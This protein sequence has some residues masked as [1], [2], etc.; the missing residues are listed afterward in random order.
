MTALEVGQSLDRYTIEALVGEGGMGQVYRAFDTRLR[1]HVALKVLR[2][3]EADP[4]AAVAEVLREA[5]AAAAIAHPNVTA[6]LDAGELEGRAFIAMEYVPGT[7]LRRLIGAA[8]VTLAARLRWLVDIAAALAAA[9]QVGVIHRDIKP[10]NV[11]VREDGLVKVLDFGVAAR[12]HLLRRNRDPPASSGPLIAATPSSEG[13]VGTPDYMAPEQLH[14]LSI[15]GRADQFGWAV[16]AHELLTGRLPWRDG[17]RDLARSPGSA[18]LAPLSPLDSSIPALVGA[19]IAR[20]LAASPADRFPSMDAVVAALTPLLAAVR[21]PA[22]SPARSTPPAADSATD[23]RPPP[24]SVSTPLIDVAAAVPATEPPPSSARLTPLP[25][26]SR[27]VPTP[28]STPA[29]WSRSSGPDLGPVVDPAAR[30]MFASGIPTPASSRPHT[31]AL[32]LR[33]PSFDAPVDL[34]EHLRRVPSGA[35]IKGIFFLELQREAEEAGM[36]PAVMLAAGLKKQ[37]Y[38]AFR[39]YSLVDNLRLVVAVA[40]HVH[41]RLSPG[42]GLRRLGQSA[43]DVVMKS[44]IG[45]AVFGLLPRDLEP[46]LLRSPKAYKLLL[47][48]GDVTV[49]K[50]SESL[51]RFHARNLPA[52]LET[53]QVGVIEGVLRH[54]DAQG[55]VL[56]AMQDVAN[57]VMEVEIL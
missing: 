46:I 20:A 48:V 21:L 38:F 44:Q 24:S 30:T 26:T 43:V 15:D 27:R 8:Q 17:T 35:T 34:D 3:P 11:M 53:Y 18:P 13:A 22:S 52:F 41:S 14:G 16:L 2:I 25:P 7:S 29:L 5:R 31:L 39:D 56:V 6:V 36:W 28:R 1:R 50:V 19:A 12:A 45:R 37:R 40:T 9:H 57:G 49:E 10:E 32:P 23:S 4:E 51:Y 55:R 47:G 33:P 54:C 42:E